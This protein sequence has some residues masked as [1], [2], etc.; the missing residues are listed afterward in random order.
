MTD[1]RE[2][3]PGTRAW[4]AQAA[5]AREG[6]KASPR[7]RAAIIQQ[8]IDSECARRNAEDR[9]TFEQLRVALDFEDYRLMSQLLN[10]AL[11]RH[12]TTPTGADEGEATES[13]AEHE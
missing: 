9:R 12:D 3:T 10:D 11:D 4:T 13:E 2:P 6:L 5:L 8:A 7:R 1:Q